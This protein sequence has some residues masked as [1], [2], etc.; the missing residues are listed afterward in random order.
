MCCA[1]QRY[2]KKVSHIT[3]VS[4]LSTLILVIYNLMYT[5]KMS[6]VEFLYM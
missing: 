2:G 6:N 1:N 3:L 5:V 4:I